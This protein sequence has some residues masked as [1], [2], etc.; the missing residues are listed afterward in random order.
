V[1]GWFTMLGGQSR[2]YLGRLNADG[3][4]D[5]G[6]NPGASSY[7]Y[8]LAVQADG[9][10]LVGGYFTTLGGQS[11]YYLGRLTPTEPATQS[12]VFDGS[13]ITWQRG[14]SSPEVWRTFFEGA[15]NGSSWIP[16]GGGTRVTGGWQLSGLAWPTNA[17]LRARGFVTGGNHNGSGWFV[18]T[19][20]GPPSIT[21][22]PTNQTVTVGDTAT[23]SV[24]ACGTSP[25][26]YQWSFNGTNIVGATNTTLTLTNVQLNQAG[27]YAV[28]VTNLLGSVL[29]SNATLTVNPVVPPSIIS[30]PTN[31]TVVAGNTASFSV[32]ASGTAPLSYRWNFDGTN[33]VGAT[34]TTLTLNNVQLNQAGSYAVLV[35][36][37]AGSILS[38]N[39]LLTVVPSLLVQNGGF[40][41]GTFDYWTT[42]GNFD[43]CSVNSDY[44]HSGV[45][46]AELGP[47]GTP[48]YIS[49]TLATTVGQRY[50]VSCWLYCDGQ[51]PN[52]FSV[53]WNGTTLFDQQNMG[54][55]LWTNLQ[56]QV[57]ATVTN[58]VLTLGF[59]DDPSSLGLDDITVYPMSDNSPLQFQTM[60][61]NNGTLSLNW[62]AQ[63]GRLYQ[64]Q[65]TTNLTQIH[66]IN[67]GGVLS[68]ANS[69]IMA[70]DDTAAA[71]MRF[72][73]IV[74]LP[75]SL[76]IP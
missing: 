10:I 14:G 74:L 62:N 29:S 75:A 49:Q 18:E 47:M 31:Q 39:A 13:T 37:A 8:S 44:V 45:Y 19:V 51:T 2:Y 55:T 46:G 7:V 58:T 22:Q 38:S 40:E 28:L 24:T 15:T 42:S 9:K 34:N 60:T 43:A 72:Y 33:I 26:N 59:Q 36:N 35:T 20:A 3:T 5:T 66:W 67:L 69:S 76:P 16:L 23:F 12:L 64:V 25:L 50:L 11:R 73:R 4:L 54:T 68:T 48:G 71:T 53:S 52:E 61:L 32:A 41:L 65:Y 63:A 6:F 27:N 21:T 56:F 17:S 57:N 1:G 70:N 30:Q